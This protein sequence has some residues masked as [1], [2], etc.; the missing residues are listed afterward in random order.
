LNVLATKKDLVVNRAL[1]DIIF[2]SSGM[3]AIISFRA[4]GRTSYYPPG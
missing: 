4:R 2:S 3:I 1:F